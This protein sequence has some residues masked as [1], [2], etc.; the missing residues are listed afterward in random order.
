MPE[1]NK[2]ARNYQISGPRKSIILTKLYKSQISLILMKKGVLITIIMISILILLLSL[3]IGFKITGRVVEHSIGPSASEQACMSNCMNCVSPGINCTGNQEQCMTQCNAQKPESTKETSCM[4][5]C[6]LVGC[7][8]FDFS[9]QG[10]NKDK[11]EKDCNM[12]GDKP[13]ESTMS[14]EQV[15]I[16]NCVE[17]VDENLR[18]G[19]SQEGETGNEICQRCAASCVHLYE[20]PCLDDEKLK[21]KEKECETCEHCYGEPVMGDSGEGWECITN[22]ECKD[23]SSEFGDMPGEGPGIGQE[24]FV[25][26]V[27]DTVGNVVEAIGNF[28]RGLFGGKEQSPNENP[29]QQENSPDLNQE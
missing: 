17:K 16:T 18:C 4:E 12:Q 10:K 19:N 15:C 29:K 28:F 25:A 13:D 26:K 3:F 22:V 5:T 6:V 14:A 8:E 2:R 20:G 21:E 23:A 24:G 9:C 7:S 1:A 27:G 11:C